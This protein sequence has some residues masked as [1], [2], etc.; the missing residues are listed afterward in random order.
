MPAT[1][2]FIQGNGVKHVQFDL[3]AFEELTSPAGH[4]HTLG[5]E[6]CGADHPLVFAWHRLESHASLPTQSHAF[7]STLADSL[8]AEARIEVFVARGCAG[9]TGLIPLCRDAGY[10]ARWRLPGARE[11]F[12]PGDA[13]VANPQAAE[14][15]A[16]GVARQHRP[17]DLD[18][19]PATSPLIPALRRAMRGR[20]LVS[21]RPAV[22][23]PTIALTPDW[24]APE[25]RFNAGR[26]SDFR[27]A[28]RRAEA[29][30]RVTYDIIAPDPGAFD[31]LFD[32]AIAVEVASWKREAGTAIASD[33]AK[34]AFFRSYFRQ[35]AGRG[36]LRLAFL[37]IDGRAAAMQIA[38]ESAGRY[39][40]FKI[41]Y[42]EAFGKCSP[43]TLLMLHTIGYAARSGL[44]AFELL[45]GVE[46][47]IA[48]LWTR[49][50]HETLRVRTYPFN[51]RGAVALAR[52]AGVWL[53]ER[54]RR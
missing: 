9:V 45:G 24:C 2:L 44:T 50:H 11:V 27:R 18:R 19:V 20:G 34:E 32:E 5:L 31:A 47:W 49:D 3:A 37:R 23:C 28:A 26:R 4:V 52:D 30:G 16:Q 29:M 48:E 10:F 14:H 39:W 35:A 54:L 33:P 1:P 42:D 41:G 22:P 43:G 51:P 40:L 38:I 8:L 46:P 6:R 17:L 13:V 36:T 7:V 12:E 15:L 21:V 25:S 53:R